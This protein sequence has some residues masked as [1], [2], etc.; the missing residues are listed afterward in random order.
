[1]SK[2]L[3]EIYYKGIINLNQSTTLDSG[4]NFLLISE[5]Y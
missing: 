4:L 2:R 5:L 3:N 1:M